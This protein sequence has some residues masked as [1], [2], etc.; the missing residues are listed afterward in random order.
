M[1]QCF[2]LVILL[3]ILG[4]P[5]AWAITGDKTTQDAHSFDS[6]NLSFM[7]LSLE[8]GLSQ[9]SGN[10]IVQDHQGYI[11]FGTQEGLNR[12]DGYKIE[13]FEHD[14][15]DPT[16]L[17]NDWIWSL[18]VDKA[19]V[20]WA[21]TDAGGVNRFN[22][23][24]KTFTSFRHNPEDDSSI[25]HD[26]VRVIYQDFSGSYWFGTD[27]G[28]LNRFDPKTNKFE[29]FQHNAEDLN[30]LPHDSVLSI[31]EDRS[32][33]LWVGT[34]GGLAKMNR[35]NG[36]FVNFSHDPALSTSLSG[37][38][39]RSIF[40]DQKG[41]LWI[42]TYEAGLNQFNP[43][44]KTF[45][46]FQHQADN[47]HSLSNNRVRDIFQDT[48]GTLWIATDGG[49]NQWLP[50]SQHFAHYNH[51]PADPS[52][53]S[54]NRVITLFQDRGGVMWVGTYNGINKWNYVSDAFTYYQKHGS[55][56]KL[57]SN[58]VTSVTESSASEVWVST[59]G[60]GLNR[61]NRLTG[62]VNYYRHDEN[63]KHSLSDDRVMTTF[64]GVDNTVWVGTRNGGL[65]KLDLNSNQ[66]THFVNDPKDPGSLSANG[67][68]SILAEANGN[69][70]VGTYGGGLNLGDAHS[71]QFKSFKHKN[72]SFV[73]YQHNPD[74][75]LSLSNNSAWDIVESSDGTFWIASGGGGLN[76][77]LAA[78]RLAGRA[79]FKSY[80]KSDGL[81]SDTVQGVLEDNA[82]FLWLSSN[83]GLQR[84]DPKSGEV[85]MYD[86]STG[87]KGN[88]F[89]TLARFKNLDGRMYFG[90]TT[91]LVAFYPNKIRT[92]QHQP[93]IVLSSHT[94]L[95]PL[96]SAHSDLPQG[97]ET[98]NHIS[99]NTVRELGYKEDLITFEFAGLDFTAPE[100][101]LY[102]YKLEGFDNDWT[103][104]AT[105]KR[106]TYTNLPA[107]DY[108]FK[109]MAS[110]N[111]GIWNEHGKSIT[112]QVIPPPWKTGLA[113]A[114]Y[115]LIAISLVIAYLR[116]QAKKLRQEVEQR[117]Y[118]E[119]QVQLRTH[120]IA[121]RNEQ[122]Q[123]LNK[124]LK[125][126]S[127]TDTLTGLNNRRYM[128]EFIEAEVAQA[129]RLAKGINE[130]G[131][132]TTIQEI[133]PAL[134]FMMID[135]DDFKAINDT[136]GHHAGDQ[137]LIQVRDILQQCCRQSDTIIRWGGDEFL[138]VSR[139]TSANA[140]E[141]LAERIRTNLADH[142][143]QLGGG[144]IARLSGSIGFALY[145][146]SLQDPDLVSWE[147][148]ANIADHAAY[149]AKENGR[150]AWVGLYGTPGTTAV[151]LTR[152]KHE[153]GDLVEK[154]ILQLNTSI[155]GEL[156]LDDQKA[157][158][159][160]AA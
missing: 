114:L 102:K 24:T 91:G 125:D 143:Y 28:G 52:S 92:N 53:L 158:P 2:S 68:T 96:D 126:A 160:S 79:V 98:T 112:L 4:M 89:N 84:F 123:D 35:R 149:V 132:K 104:P 76:R 124:K 25:S 26:R 101:N 103:T 129:N 134:S 41:Q 153:L 73:R 44:T 22:P 75:P 72:Q 106:T 151:E 11:W 54:D 140:V 147:Q 58:I 117:I 43:V 49:L 71:G 55:Q 16:S 97:S 27:G 51:D 86:I 19:G 56:L 133:A 23:D 48:E 152:I 130:S 105:F 83:R 18:L 33:N 159:R 62:E 81:H 144:N 95:G 32:G 69:V 6:R 7:R 34:K 157:T 94:R 85:R 21:G 36:Q 87:L 40:E 1:L 90:G 64:V 8:Q 29:R 107:G 31:L 137:A 109:V 139:N 20:V 108:T 150:N 42:G 9:S 78:D 57:S 67:V 148:V 138:I 45:T 66:F 38:Q 136:Y 37:N 141:T 111:D 65:N 10:A 116:A 142:L 13:V 115:A 60:G 88:E 12:Y 80:R 113:Y 14:H 135:L 77:W 120:E 30:S 3:M 156:N 154:D 70:W 5:M 17:T 99:H 128:D 121:E 100:K 39:V 145:P 119:D 47:A 59:Y 46:R 82:G 74:D 118:L 131:E 50:K 61:L 110:N 15:K 146:F 155:T 63:D 122:L 93:D 127:V